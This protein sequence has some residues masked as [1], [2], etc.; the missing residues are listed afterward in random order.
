MTNP[1][2][3][4]SMIDHTLLKP[5]ATPEQIAALCEEARDYGF[6]SVCVNPVYVPLAARTL[7]G[8]DVQVCTVVGFPLGA[9]STAI[10]AHEAEQ[11]IEQGANE[12]DMV[13]HI[14]SLK[15][16]DLRHLHHDIAAVVLACHAHEGVICKVII[17][18]ALL[19]DE[20]KTIACQIAKEARAD[21]VKT[22][23]GFSTG[24]ATVED[25]RLMR[26]IVG[27][28]VGVKASGG[29][30]SMADAIAMIEAGAT[31]IGASSGVAIAQEIHG[32]AP[33]T[34]DSSDY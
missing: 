32:D 16:R 25:V 7:T 4:P 1:N 20:E 9:T 34:G 28:N 17:E 12:I 27:E 29:V 6:A 30:R 8:T 24:G 14:G 19:T 3:I 26:E 18:T 15:A 10:K 2:V 23:T 21:F 31:R 33:V 11:A 5:D 22:S 13:L